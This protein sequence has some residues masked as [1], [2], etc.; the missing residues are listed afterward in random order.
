MSHED[1][2]MERLS[3]LMDKVLEE[4]HREG[5]EH[6]QIFATWNEQGKTHF[7]KNGTGNFYARIGMCQEFLETQSSRVHHHVRY[8]EFN[9]EEE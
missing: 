5:M 4:L 9:H 7:L 1:K 6:I 2:E 3:K 8:N